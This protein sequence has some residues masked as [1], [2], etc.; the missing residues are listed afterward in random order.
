M[1]DGA[2]MSTGANP[3]WSLPRLLTIFGLTGFAISQ[4]LLSVLG[5]NPTAFVSFGIDGWRIVA[6]ALAVV[7][8]PP[9]VLWLTISLI[10]TF[11]KRLAEAVFLLSIGML[12]AIAAIQLA[13]WAGISSRYGLQ[14]LA[15]VAGLGMVGAYR[16]F[17]PIATWT[18]YLSP[19]PILALALFLFASP[20]GALLGRESAAS[21]SA[22]R[23]S[24]SPPVVMIVLDEF[25]TKSLLDGDN[26]I[27][28]VR[29]PNLAAFAQ[30][31]TW[32]R[33]FTTMSPF[34]AS[35]VPSLL[36]GQLPRTDLP[37]YTN[38]PDSVFSML[39][40]TH[41]LAVFESAT[42][43]CNEPGCSGAAGRDPQ[44]GD[45]V[46]TAVDLVRA[47]VAFDASPESS[48]DDFVE[49]Q[50]E[51]GDDAFGTTGLGE[52]LAGAGLEAVPDRVAAFTAAFKA[53]ERPGFY[54]LHLMLPH[55]PWLRYDSGAAYS[56]PD[57]FR[58]RLPPADRAH[59]DWWA[60]WPAAV[61][62][63]RHLLQATYTDAVVGGVFDELAA[64]GLYED[65]LVIVVADHGVSF[66]PRQNDREPSDNTM[67]DV[68]YVPLLVK[69]PHQRIGAIDDSNLMSI[70]LVP[71]IA[72]L[73][74]A[75]P[76]WKIDGAVVGS[77]DVASRGDV[78]QWYDI[79]DAFAPVLLGVVEFSD[80]ASFPSALERHIAPIA[81][82]D[83]PLDAMFATLNIP[84][85][86][87][88]PFD[89][90][91]L[92]PLGTAR[93]MGASQLREPPQ[94]EPP[95]GVVTGVIDGL[96]DNVEN[97]GVF[98]LSVNGVVVTG[99]RITRDDAGAL[100]IHALIPEG[101]LGS[102]NELR[103]AVVTFLGTLELNV[104]D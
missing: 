38:Y 78:K 9:L 79:A 102:S 50:V 101:V 53:S 5:D 64:A 1:T 104:S 73:V 8:V 35:A 55:R 12:S 40:P 49:V 52:L 2:V 45:L 85:V 32:Y 39:A 17:P 14:L 62:E 80:S 67:G 81:R 72:E 19:L 93:L 66:A 100:R 96:P 11:S 4:P 91:N 98:V 37:F 83:D 86:I 7:A 26:R 48:L 43:L 92:T 47:R 84:D 29:F 94:D 95:I 13:K 82:A 65:S 28:P 54:F 36:T 34:T 31:A 68:A 6:F 21:P 16:R 87:G 57:P 76:D 42:L 59:N 22:R 44:F 60:T 97:D 90:L 41:D 75:T 24:D 10:G 61:T 77:P 63:Q 103:A 46:A 69:Q 23:R 88:R 51:I 18:R 70:D 71:I 27:D 3:V 30:D 58:R 89:E 33:H 20:S 25:P 74:G 99:S 56:S 15:L